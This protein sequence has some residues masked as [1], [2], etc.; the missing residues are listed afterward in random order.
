MEH[1]FER[2]AK[3][4]KCLCLLKVQCCSL[5]EFKLLYLEQLP[6]WIK[7]DMCESTLINCRVVNPRETFLKIHA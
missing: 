5:F 7:F 4:P 2:G 6:A 3:L 1:H